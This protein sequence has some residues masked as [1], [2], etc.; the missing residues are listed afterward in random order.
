MRKKKWITAA[1]LSFALIMTGCGAASEANTDNIKEHVT[2]VTTEDLHESESK[3]TEEK[4]K[5]VTKKVNKKTTEEKTEEKEIEK[6]EEEETPD[7]EE[8]SDSK[9]SDKDAYEE[10][11]AGNN[12]IS[13]DY[14]IA[15]VYDENDFSLKQPIEKLNT[16][17]QYTLSELRDDLYAGLSQGNLESMEYAYIDCGADGVKEMALRIHG[18]FIEENS[19]VTYVVKEMDSSLQ[20]VYAYPEWSRSS[21]NLNEYGFISGGG[22]N[23]ATNHCYEVA[24]INAEGKYNYGYYQ[25]EESNVDQFAINK[26]HSDY[27]LTNLEG[28]ICVYSLRL[29][30]YSAENAEPVA[31]SYNVYNKD[32][33]ESMEVPNL[34][35]DSPYKTVMDSFTGYEFISMDELK[36]KENEKLES[37]GVTEEIQNGETPGFNEI[38]F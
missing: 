37:I 30:P 5:K 21:T 20:V 26:E 2:E 6:E 7:Q 12:T 31:Y 17:K 10:F 23:G 34:Y 28:N 4:T 24:Y 27:D 13:F 38:S 11:L 3:T 15:N 33:N 29:D 25:E 35:S 1:V 14:Y 32:T 19:S 8:V 36:Q 22:S 16:E 18:S 9:S